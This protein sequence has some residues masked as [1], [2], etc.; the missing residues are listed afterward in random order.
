MRVYHVAWYV[1]EI[2][3]THVVPPRKTYRRNSVPL[4]LRPLYYSYS[5]SLN[6]GKSSRET[7]A[8]L[9]LP[10]VD[11]LGAPFSH[12]RVEEE[13][14]T[15]KK[16]RKKKKKKRREEET[17]NVSTSFPRRSALRNS[18]RRVDCSLYFA[19]TL[20]SSCSF[21]RPTYSIAFHKTDGQSLF[22]ISVFLFLL[23]KRF[24]LSLSLSLLRANC[25][26]FR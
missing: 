9:A 3:V 26:V 25:H 20:P 11:S 24:S 12:G 5:S 18:R 8:A 15:K 6:D 10:P 4:L 7:A 21:I 23:I 2:K 13:T 22:E 1:R 17:R 16:K 19:F 14:K